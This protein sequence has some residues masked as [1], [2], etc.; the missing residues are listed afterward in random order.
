MLQQTQ[1]KTVL[2]YYH[3][4]LKR[5][6][7]IQH[8]AAADSQEVLK[9]WEGLGYYGRARNLHQ[10]ARMVMQEMGGKIPKEY[11]AFRKLPGVGDYIGAAVMSLAFDR[12]HAVVDG[13]VKRVIARLFLIDSPLNSSFAVRQC[14]HNA[15]ELLDP[16]NPGL[17]N[18]AMMELGATVCLPR[19]PRCSACPVTPFCQAHKAGRQNQLP[20]IIRAKSISEHDIAVGIVFKNSHV[21]ITRRRPA[22]LLGGLWEFPGGKVQGGETAE[23]A[24]VREIKEELNLS[25]EIIGFLTRIKHAYTHFRIVMDV[26]RCRY[27]SGEVLLKGPIDYRWITIDEIDQYPFPGANHKF[28]PLLKRQMGKGGC[29]ESR[30]G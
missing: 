20:V 4:F 12:P 7:D 1:V 29:R 10:A 19:G 23:R 25:V 27:L 24:C 15:D 18:Q 16:G 26:F 17:F 5:F 13:N 21:L 14:R 6:P 11:Q 8:L 2:P 3:R 22:G 9:G 30:V 28:I